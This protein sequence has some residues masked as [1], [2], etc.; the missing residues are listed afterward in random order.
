[1]YINNLKEWNELLLLG[2]GCNS[3]LFNNE[4]LNIM[5][6][7]A[8]YHGKIKASYLLE[9]ILKEIKKLGK[10]LGTIDEYFEGLRLIKRK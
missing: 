9:E 3:G 1:M 2:Y 10:S 7:N 5:F 4:R 8:L 6:E